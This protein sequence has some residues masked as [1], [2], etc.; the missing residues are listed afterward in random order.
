MDGYCDPCE[1]RPI[2]QAVCVSHSGVAIAEGSEHT[3][4]LGAG[5]PPTSMTAGR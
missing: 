4:M 5:H 1:H 2:H 3:E